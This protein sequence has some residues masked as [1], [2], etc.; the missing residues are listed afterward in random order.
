M[1]IIGAGLAGCIAAALHG[2]AKIIEA[3]EEIRINHS[4]VLQFRSDAVS[5]AIGIPFKKVKVYKSVFANGRHYHTPD[6][7]IANKY[8]KKVIGRI[9]ER[10]IWNLEPC[11]RWVAPPNFH[12]MLL[13]IIGE[14]RISC[15]H[16]VSEFQKSGENTIIITSK[17][18]IES[19]N[20]ISTIPLPTAL[21]A[22][23][24]HAIKDEFKYK[25]INVYRQTIEDCD[26]YQTVYFPYENTHIYRVTLTGGDLIVEL[27][28]DH[29][30]EEK[31]CE[32]I[33]QAFGIEFYQSEFKRQNQ[34]YGK[35]SPI[36]ERTR[37]TLLYYLTDTTG[38][39]QLGRFAIWKNILLD[40]VLDDIF[41]IRRMKQSSSFKYNRAKK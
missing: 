10:S 22:A 15:G 27:T 5:L 37:K 3:S 7:V 19:D 13:D 40:D 38:I 26:V 16:E 24:I 9:A 30:L 35:L 21:R 11:T 39:F 20:V 28:G 41:A 6:P 8:S 4:A 18:S 25:S 23:G 34:K 17:D 2:D 36:A 32:L 31:D 14:S 33:E 29:E 12:Q 1:V